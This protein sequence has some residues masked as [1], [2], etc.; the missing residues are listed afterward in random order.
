MVAV[1]GVFIAALY[2]LHREL[3]HVNLHEV[4]WTFAPDDVTVMLPV[5]AALVGTI[6]VVMMLTLSALTQTNIKATPEDSNTRVVGII[7]VHQ[8]GL[9]GDGVV[10]AGMDW[11][12][13]AIYVQVSIAMVLLVLKDGFIAARVVTHLEQDTRLIGPVRARSV[14]RIAVEKHRVANGHFNCIDRE[15]I[16][17][18]L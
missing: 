15:P 18:C 10:L 1:L 9:T 4:V 13:V 17:D 7:D 3:A 5:P 8:P 6:G 12:L 2:V 16:T 11:S 14:Q